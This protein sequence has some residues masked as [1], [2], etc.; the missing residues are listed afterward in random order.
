M[1]GGDAGSS[2]ITARQSWHT[3]AE[4]GLKLPHWG[5]GTKSMMRLFGAA[6]TNTRVWGMPG[7]RTTL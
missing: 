5:Q 7:G 3:F 1:L 4:G 6:Y 2:G